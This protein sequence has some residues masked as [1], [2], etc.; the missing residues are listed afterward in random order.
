[1]RLSMNDKKEIKQIIAGFTDADYQEIDKE[2]ER[3]C[4]SAQPILRRFD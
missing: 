3:L 4:A 1:M 2:V